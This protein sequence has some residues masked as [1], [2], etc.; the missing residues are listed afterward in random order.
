M[1]TEQ[2]LNDIV[3]QLQ[4]D[5]SGNLIDNPILRPDIQVN[6]HW[7]YKDGLAEAARRILKLEPE[8]TSPSCSAC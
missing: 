2:Q 4:K 5:A 1:I 7:G 8:A 3:A 6:Y